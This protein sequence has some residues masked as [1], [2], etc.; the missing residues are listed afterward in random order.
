MLLVVHNG[1]CAVVAKGGEG[2][3]SHE[4]LPAAPTLQTIG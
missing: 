3:A 4:C 2:R 1:G